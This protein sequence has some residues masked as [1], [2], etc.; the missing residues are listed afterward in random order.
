MGR[1]MTKLSLMNYSDRQRAENGE[2]SVAE[3]RRTEIEALVDTGAATLILP[4]DAI[5]PLG[6]RVEGTK[7]VRYAD[8]R[9]ESVPWVSGLWIELCGR[10][11]TCDALVIP[12]GTVA[13]VG[14]IPLEFLDLVVDPRSQQILP[15][16]D[17]PDGPLMDLLRVT[18]R[19][20]EPGP[21]VLRDELLVAQA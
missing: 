4:V 14:Q 20:R 8:G 2:I 6:L 16:P 10:E 18:T 15:N 12:K 19:L 3:I 1:V 17:H 11:M 5:Q 21:L 13:L 7:P 9:V